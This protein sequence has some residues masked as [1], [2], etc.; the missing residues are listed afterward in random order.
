M[1]VERRGGRGGAERASGKKGGW[2]GWGGWGEMGG[3][4]GGGR[5]E[6]ICS[7]ISITFPGFMP[8]APETV[9]SQTRESLRYCVGTFIA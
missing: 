1:E 5:R 8:Y 3:K 6:S 9:Q 2:V 4:G 7:R